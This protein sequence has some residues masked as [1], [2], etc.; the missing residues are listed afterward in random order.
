MNINVTVNTTAF[1]ANFKKGEKLIKAAAERA[2]TAAVIEL[3]ERVEERTP[4]GNPALWNWPAPKNYIPGKLKASWDVNFGTIGMTRVRLRANGVIATISND[5]PYAQRVEYG[6][7]S[8]APQGMLR[9]SLLE[10]PSILRKQAALYR[11]R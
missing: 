10:L 3:K 11:V 5:Q 4:V 7:S 9:I 6:W 1:L 2:L 8:Q